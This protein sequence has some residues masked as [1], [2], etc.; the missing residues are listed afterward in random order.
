M[1]TVILPPKIAGGTISV[2][3]VT[4]EGT[5]PIVIVGANGSGKTRMGAQI[6]SAASEKAHRVSAQRA[7]TIPH[8]VQPRTHT[9]AE[10]IL[11]YGHY[12]PSQNQSIR[13]EQKYGNR[14]SG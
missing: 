11:L 2:D 7:L 14:W 5:T 3:S 10:A 4:F 9:Q 13:V 6:E 12:D 1:T 8:F